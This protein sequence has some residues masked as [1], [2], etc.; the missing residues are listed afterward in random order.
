MKGPFRL[1][2]SWNLVAFTVIPDVISPRKLEELCQERVDETTKLTIQ[3]GTTVR[4]EI[5]GVAALQSLI[6]IPK[7]VGSPNP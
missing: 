4:V 7:T 6:G 5:E 1:V 2:V 3:H